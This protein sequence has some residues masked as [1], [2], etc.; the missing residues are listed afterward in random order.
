MLSDRSEV[1]PETLHDE[2]MSMVVE[3]CLNGVGAFP[4]SA[5]PVFLKCFDHGTV[6]FCTKRPRSRLFYSVIFISNSLVSEFDLRFSAEV[7][8]YSGADV[9]VSDELLQKHLVDEHVLVH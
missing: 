3:D 2:H 4:N 1:F 8:E 7:V 9:F 5:L 6:Q